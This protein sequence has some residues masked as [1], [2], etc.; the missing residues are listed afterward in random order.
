[1]YDSRLLSSLWN[2]SNLPSA[3]C[4]FFCEG[5][6]NLKETGNILMRYI[7]IFWKQVAYREMF[8]VKYFFQLLP[9]ATHVISHVCAPT[10][11]YLLTHPHLSYESPWVSS[12][13]F[14]TDMF[15][16]G[17]LCLAVSKRHNGGV[18]VIVPLEGAD[19]SKY[20]EMTGWHNKTRLWKFVKM[21][22]VW[23]TTGRFKRS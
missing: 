1:M 10:L 15:N 21:V 23:S 11:W 4:S 22:C 19:G 8:S 12:G 14:N 7:L 3:T 17:L 18:K 20:M 6:F 16:E 5:V 9:P 13:P 2:G